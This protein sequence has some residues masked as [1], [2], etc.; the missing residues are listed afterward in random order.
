M[1]THSLNAELWLPQSRDEVFQFFSDP[2]NLEA[3]TP[4]WLKFSILTPGP[5][6]MRAGALLDYSLRVHGLPM[7]WQSEI[8]V[9]E[10][11]FCFVDEQRRGPY[12]SWVHKHS[13]FEDSGGTLCRDEINYVVPGGRFINWLIVRRDVEKIFEYRRKAIGQ[14]FFSKLISCPGEHPLSNGFSNR[15]AS[16]SALS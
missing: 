7:S 6:A 1:T 10:P 5:T 8:T 13:F 9:W 3:I 14:H 4:P 15:F 11:P 12:R 16:P 2:R